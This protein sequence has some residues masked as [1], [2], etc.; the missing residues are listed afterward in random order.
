MTNTVSFVSNHVLATV[1]GEVDGALEGTYKEYASKTTLASD[2]VSTLG[3]WQVNAD[4]HT[5]VR[6]ASELQPILLTITIRNNSLERALSF[7]LSG[8][9]YEAWN[10]V[11]LGEMNI[12]RGVTYSIDNAAPV[13]NALYTSQIVNVEPTKTAVIVISLEIT[14]TGISVNDFD[15]SF[16]MILSNVPN[17]EVGG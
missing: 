13:N 3:E 14:D 9:L 10:G 11:N 1:T 4:E 7:E 6:F 5:H 15:N 8:F 12:T 2:S 16:T 17:G